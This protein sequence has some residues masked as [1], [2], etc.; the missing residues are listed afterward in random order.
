M[1][2][3]LFTVFF[4]IYPIVTGCLC[5][6][7]SVG[8]PFYNTVIIPIVILFLFFMSIGPKVRWIKDNIGNLKTTLM[9]LLGSVL[10][11]LFIFLF[12]S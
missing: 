4:T 10:I 7:I 5:Q 12:L 9:I 11:N 8:P 3:Y 6:K 1:I 2:F